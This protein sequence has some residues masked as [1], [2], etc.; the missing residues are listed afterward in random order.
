M[1]TNLKNK[2]SANA[3]VTFADQMQPNRRLTL[4]ALAVAAQKV[5]ADKLLVPAPMGMM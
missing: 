1:K 3:V 4:L 2:S 5:V